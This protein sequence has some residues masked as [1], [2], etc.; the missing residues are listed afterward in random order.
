MQKFFLCLQITV[1]V[2]ARSSSFGSKKQESFSEPPQDAR[3][4]SVF[5]EWLNDGWT[6]N[7]T[8][9]SPQHEGTRTNTVSKEDVPNW[10]EWDPLNESQKGI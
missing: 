10:L 3:L 5:D 4:T 1:L 9:A 6:S 2:T 8:S 7:S